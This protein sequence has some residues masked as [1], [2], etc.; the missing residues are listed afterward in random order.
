[1]AM[2]L[3]SEEEEKGRVLLPNQDNKKRLGYTLGLEGGFFF[4]KK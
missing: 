1:M 3:S 4:Y 2:T